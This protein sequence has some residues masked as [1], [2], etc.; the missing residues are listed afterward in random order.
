[1][2]EGFEKVAIAV[3]LLALSGCVKSA[4]KVAILPDASCRLPAVTWSVD[5]TP[6]TIDKVRRLAAARAKL[7]RK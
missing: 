5:D 7:C 2:P 1:M 6:E 4:P 3:L